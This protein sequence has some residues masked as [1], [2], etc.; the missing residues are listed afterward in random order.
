MS[1]Y[2]SFATELCLPWSDIDIVVIIPSNSSYHYM[3]AA[4]ILTDIDD[5]LKVFKNIYFLA[6]RLGR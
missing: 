4:D 1:V 5:Q 2:G 3:K 6:K